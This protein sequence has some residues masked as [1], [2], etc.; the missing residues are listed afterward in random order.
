MDHEMIAA[1]HPDLYFELD[2]FS[3]V[4]PRHWKVPRESAPGVPE[5]ND[6]VVRRAGLGHR[7]SRAVA[8]LA[9]AAAGTRARQNRGRSIPSC[10]ASPATIRLPRR[11]RAGGRSAA[12]PGAVPG[13]PPWNA[14]RYAV[15]RELAHQVDAGAADQLDA[16]IA[17]LSKLMSQLNPDREAVAAAAEGA[18]AAADRFVARIQAQPYDQA[19]TLRLL[20]RISADAEEISA[21]RGARRRTGHHGA[22]FA[23][24]RLHQKR[25]NRACR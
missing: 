25:A 10:N 5:Q 19:F 7:A 22:R 8:R 4:M 23:L 20:D 21:A 15:F 17:Q 13:D 24:H 3:A 6:A 16:Q 2:S 12:I 9:G 1:G 11:S 18:Q 14:S